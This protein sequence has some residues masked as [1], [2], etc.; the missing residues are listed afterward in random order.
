MKRSQMCTLSLNVQRLRHRNDKAMPFWQYRILLI[1]SQIDLKT[2][3][4]WLKAG[5]SCRR[6]QLIHS[7]LGAVFN[8]PGN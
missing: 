2:A 4:L 8:T 3:K 6:S 1:P 7:Q 5:P